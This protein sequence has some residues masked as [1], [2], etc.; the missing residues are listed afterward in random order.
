MYNVT[1]SEYLAKCNEY[2]QNKVPKTPM[3]HC[4]EKFVRASLNLPSHHLCGLWCRNGTR[5]LYVG[6]LDLNC[7]EAKLFEIFNP[8]RNPIAIHIFRHHHTCFTYWRKSLGFAR[9]TFSAV[10]DIKH[11]LV[12]LALNT[13]SALPKFSSVMTEPTTLKQ[14]NNL[15]KIILR[16]N[17]NCVMQ[18][19]I[20][21]KR[22]Q[23]LIDLK[24]SLNVKE[25]V[26]TSVP[27][28]SSFSHMS[29]PLQKKYFAF[30]T[31]VA[32]TR[33]F[34]FLELTKLDVLELKHMC[35]LFNNTFSK[36][37]TYV[38]IPSKLYPS[39]EV[40]EQKL[41]NYMNKENILH[42]ASRC[43]SPKICDDPF[44]TQICNMKREM[45]V[46]WHGCEICS[47]MF[48]TWKECRSHK[49][50]GW[51]RC[52]NK[53]GSKERCR[54][55]AMDYIEKILNYRKK[56]GQP[57]EMKVPVVLEKVHLAS[58]EHWDRCDMYPCTHLKTGRHVHDTIDV[59]IRCMMTYDVV[60]H[61]TT[62]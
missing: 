31:D 58:H 5:A 37:P 43:R 11:V 10:E 12:T 8:I 23:S 59:D 16:S 15:L 30:S 28:R 9:I 52:R 48:S 53:Q 38:I 47:G 1:W 46:R 62:Y 24:Q 56:H 6:D 19:E 35:K 14:K 61:A 3:I 2:K 7:D 51:T 22:K 36:F 21:E 54:R 26:Y 32:W 13:N 44:H 33:V 49:N 45:D 60:R 50:K 27:F 4:M 17:K 42:L 40:Y 39:F 18:L 57:L 41:K 34:S 55:T 25:Y 20:Q 29:A